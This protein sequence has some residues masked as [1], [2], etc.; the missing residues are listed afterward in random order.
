LYE[1]PIDLLFIHVVLPFTLEH[2]NIRSRAWTFAM[3]WL[4]LVT[5]SLK[6]EDYILKSTAN[7][8]H[9]NDHNNQ[10]NDQNETSALSAI[11]PDH[12]KLRLLIFLFLL[13]F[14]L[15]FVN[16][17]VI[18][19]P[20]ILGRMCLHGWLP[21]LL[22]DVYTFVLGLYIIWGIAELTKYVIIRV[23]Q[24]ANHIPSFYSILSYLIL[25]VK[26]V[27]IGG[28]WFGVIPLLIG[29]WF[30][31]LIFIPL[32]VQPNQTPI[33]LYYHDYAFGLLY[34]KLWYRLIMINGVSSSWKSK[35]EQVKANGFANLQF[36]N[37]FHT[38]LF[39]IVKF[40][41][42]MLCIPYCVGII[43]GSMVPGSSLEGTWVAELLTGRIL[44]LYWTVQ[45][46][47]LV[48]II[49]VF[50]WVSELH[51]QIRDDK[52]LVGQRLHNFVPYNQP[53]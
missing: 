49:C 26:C 7:A 21:V 33:F 27:G 5:T 13:W 18:T 41:L 16:M 46:L 1:G 22:N 38:I 29:I 47:T 36:W 43:A 9:D 3:S 44:Y 17:S 42:L 39:P 15:S 14:T 52:Y 51:R 35:F 31:L 20:I 30:E 40:L 45:V 53:L 28:I 2:S 24:H 11:K 34:L 37:V 32:R 25:A 23:M 10:H 19:L 8:P 6:L 12:F 4:A 50:N 48:C